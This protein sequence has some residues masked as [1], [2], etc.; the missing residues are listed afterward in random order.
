MSRNDLLTLSTGESDDSG[1]KVK[2]C[3]YS[4]TGRGNAWIAFVSTATER[5]AWCC[6]FSASRYE[7]VKPATSPTLLFAYESRYNLSVRAYAGSLRWL[8][9]IDG[10]IMAV[11]MRLNIIS[12]R[13]TYFVPRVTGNPACRLSC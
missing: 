12:V 7:L 2:Q 10:G 13:S 3:T 6:S 4:A 9:R 1:K 11:S 8:S 5:C